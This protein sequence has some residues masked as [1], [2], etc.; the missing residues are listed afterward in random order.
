MQIMDFLSQ[1]GSLVSYLKAD[2]NDTSAASFGHFLEQ[3]KSQYPSSL[4]QTQKVSLADTAAKNNVQ[5]PFC[6]SRHGPAGSPA[7]LQEARYSLLNQPGLTN[8]E[9]MQI[10]MLSEAA[11]AYE[12]NGPPEMAAK[13]PAYAD[14]HSA[15]FDPIRAIMSTVNSLASSYPN[16]ARIGNEWAAMQK[17]VAAKIA[18]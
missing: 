10:F 6:T 4:T 13:F 18:I 8:K 9:R 2:A 11:L 17:N 1:A 16:I 5:I 14:A 3:A 12:R 15:N 7:G